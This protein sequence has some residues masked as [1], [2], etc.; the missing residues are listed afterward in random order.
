MYRLREGKEKKKSQALQGGAWL[1][2]L[3]KAKSSSGR[4]K[5]APAAGHQVGT[6]DFCKNSFL[7]LWWRWV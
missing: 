7:I 2:V 3:S 1:M 5:E 6:G 4:R